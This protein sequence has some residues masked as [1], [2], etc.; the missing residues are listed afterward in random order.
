MTNK[1]NIPLSNVSEIGAAGLKQ[2]A[3]GRKFQA[4]LLVT[5]TGVAGRP[6]YILMSLNQAS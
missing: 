6:N 4:N 2:F 1:N 5:N 3:F